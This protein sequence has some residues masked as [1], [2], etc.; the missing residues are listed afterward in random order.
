MINEIDNSLYNWLFNY[1]TYTK[2]W[3]AFHRDDK[4]AY[5]GNGNECKSKIASKTIDTLL[6]MII[7]TK[8][9][10]KN[11]DTIIDFRDDE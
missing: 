10:P 7:T 5:F 11:F 6:Y 9:N 8:G 1:N 2:Q 4:E 3:N